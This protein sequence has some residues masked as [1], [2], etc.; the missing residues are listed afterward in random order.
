MSYPCLPKPFLI[1]SHFNTTENTVFKAQNPFVLGACYI[2]IS[3]CY[4]PL[5]YRISLDV[6]LDIKLLTR[7]RG[8]KKSNNSKIKIM[9]VITIFLRLTT[10]V[11][12]SIFIFS[13]EGEDG[14]TGPAG[15][16]GPQGKQ[17]LQVDQG[18][19]GEQGSQ[20][21]QGTQGEQGSQGDQGEQGEQGETGTANV[22][23]S[24]WIDSGFPLDI[25][26]SSDTFEIPAPQIT[27]EISN[28]GVVLVYAQFR[29]F[30]NVL[31]I[32]AVVANRSYYFNFIPGTLNITVASLDGSNVGATSFG[33]YRYV[34]I[35]GGVAASK[36]DA[37][38]DYTKMSYEEIV[39]LFNIPN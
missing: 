28:S 5:I 16:Q 3:L 8:L 12:L 29:T 32:P 2:C 31:G 26:S 38:T 25:T 21:D 20:G 17:G 39:D 35:P 23:Y 9:K 14:A 10:V 19:Q 24:E 37:T 18:T 4:I 30:I 11:V 27:E 6:S 15:A 33:S 1:S 36:S 13:C 22:I 7:S 34:I